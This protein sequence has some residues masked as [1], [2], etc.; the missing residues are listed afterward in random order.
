MGILLSFSKSL[1]VGILFPVDIE[2]SN[3]RFITYDSSFYFPNDV[4]KLE[5]IRGLNFLRQL[6]MDVIANPDELLSFVTNCEKES[7]DT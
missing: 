1:F 5:G 6:V 3:S 2:F 4:L 7:S